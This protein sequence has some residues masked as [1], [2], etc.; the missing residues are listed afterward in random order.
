MTDRLPVQNIGKWT[1]HL[2]KA[3]T[4]QFHISSEQEASTPLVIEGHDISLLLD[5]LYEYRELIYEATHDQER[6][7]LEALEG[8]NGRVAS[9]MRDRQ[10][11]R[12]FYVDDGSGRIQENP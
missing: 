9:P 2:Q 7:R 8:H 3:Q 6:R 1:V 5:Y 12:V 11:E 10:V 4:L